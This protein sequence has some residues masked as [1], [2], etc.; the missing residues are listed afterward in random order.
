MS[1]TFKLEGVDGMMAQLRSA[2]DDVRKEYKGLVKRTTKR[3]RDDAVARVNR[4][5][6]NLADSAQIEE[7]SGGYY[8]RVRFK[9]PHAHL[10]EHGTVHAPAHPFLGPAS[11]AAEFGFYQEAERIL[12]DQGDDS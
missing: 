9:A 6:G 5:T 3:I 2:E 7:S 4:V 10:V 11:A 1:I 12:K 8:G